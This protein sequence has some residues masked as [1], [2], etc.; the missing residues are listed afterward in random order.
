MSGSTKNRARGVDVAIPFVYGSTAS[1]I[2]P[3]DKPSDPSHTH[4]WAVYLR[5]VDGQDLSVYI[6]KVEFKLHESFAEPVRAITKPPF[7]V[8]E[9]GWGEF[10]IAIRISF[11]DP[12]EKI[13]T[14][15]HHLQL[16]P[17]NLP[18]QSKGL[19]NVVSEHYEEIVQ[20]I[21]FTTGIP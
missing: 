8:N 7:E 17:A 4:K 1:L 9:T 16:H 10:E 12:N 15:S 20:K 18:D 21:C 13:L 11:N 3:E 14:V 19:N 2:G 5:G 6:A